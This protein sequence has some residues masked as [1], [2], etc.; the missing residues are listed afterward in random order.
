MA[1]LRDNGEVFLAREEQ[2]QRLSRQRLVVYH[3][4]P[5]STRWRDAGHDGE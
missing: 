5:P 1:A 3:N 4:G 2:S